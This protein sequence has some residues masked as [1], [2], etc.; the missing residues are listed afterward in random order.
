M[1]SDYGWAEKDDYPD[2]YIE[3]S[4]SINEIIALDNDFGEGDNENDNEDYIPIV[5]SHVIPKKKSSFVGGPVVRGKKRKRRQL[6]GPEEFFKLVLS[7][8]ID[9]LLLGTRKALNLSPLADMPAHFLNQQI[10]FDTMRQIAIEEARATLTEG[11]KTINDQMELR[12]SDVQSCLEDS[13]VLLIVLKIVKGDMDLTRPGTVFKLFQDESRRNYTNNNNKSY[14]SNS[15]NSNS[16]GNGN[17]RSSSNNSNGNS[18]SN[19]DR[20]QNQ[21][22]DS[23]LAVVAQGS[24]AMSL[25]VS[26]GGFTSYLPLWINPFSPLAKRLISEGDSSKGSCWTALSLGSVLS[27]QRMATVCSESPSPPFMFKLLGH[28]PS[29]HIKFDSDSEDESNSKTGASANL[30]VASIHCGKDG[31]NRKDGNSADNSDIEVDDR[32]SSDND[33]DNDV[34]I[35]SDDDSDV[36][37]S[38]ILPRA[39]MTQLSARSSNRL[40]SL[41]VSQSE[42]LRKC[43]GTGI[44]ERNDGTGVQGSAS[45]VLAVS[46]GNLHLILGP[47]GCGKTHF[48]V[49]T[50]HALVAKGNQR[51]DGSY[52]RIMV[53]APSNKAV[54]VVLEQF[55]Q[56]GVVGAVGDESRGVRCCLVGVMD[57]LEGCSTSST[58]STTTSTST[59]S[60]ASA[61]T[62]A[63]SQDRTRYPL[64]LLPPSATD[65][66]SRFLHPFGASDVFVA[67]YGKGMSGAFRALARC[68]EDCLSRV[69]SAVTY[70]DGGNITAMQGIAGGV[71]W[72]YSLLKAIRSEGDSLL[73]LIQVDATAFFSR[74]INSNRIS[75]D[76]EFEKI[77][78]LLC[79]VCPLYDGSHSIAEN[80]LSYTLSLAGEGEQSRREEKEQC[81]SMTE[82]NDVKNLILASVQGVSQLLR[83]VANSLVQGS[84]GDDLAAAVLQSSSIVF[85][86][87]TSAGSGIVKKNVFNV[88]TL[89][90]DEAAQ[91]LEVELLIPLSATPRNL[92]LVGD[93]KQL[94]ACVLSMENQRSKRGESAMQRLMERCAYPALLLDTQYRMHPAISLLP[95]RLFYESSLRDSTYV[96][97]RRCIFNPI[98]DH[99][100]GSYTQNTTLLKGINSACSSSSSRKGNVRNVSTLPG[101]LQ[102]YSFIDVPS[103]EGSGEKG[104]GK[105]GKSL[106]NEAE[107][108]VVVK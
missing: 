67:T 101:W 24:Q 65:L 2:D 17:S 86:T 96:L 18:N 9:N 66:T 63:K 53:C 44:T 46:D 32:S 16:H 28:R 108:Q 34:D 1:E 6:S 97:N 20:N 52:E 68:Q 22:I 51:C 78:R 13:P 10:Y 79:T 36:A 49:A 48:L 89:V 54:C 45:T 92:I 90:V 99:D 56:S 31:N 103:T 106:S 11:L 14:N 4:K 3:S 19:S 42:A 33:N 98:S 43:L 59:S 38:G 26:M 88:D 5:K 27:Y 75:I 23:V 85:C 82:F 21:N 62:S 35:D 7:W 94:P 64:P 25:V 80:T 58:A 73:N 12:M 102:N 107:A 50:L 69:D 81:L 104:G 76:K 72:V 39:L 70:S 47:P 30:T 93:P 37:Y 55:L 105:L 84:A 83:D 87:L 57:K 77:F 91:A 71:C 41:N 60:S 15:S 8:T 40:N 95:N 61:T 29:S 74:H 100:H